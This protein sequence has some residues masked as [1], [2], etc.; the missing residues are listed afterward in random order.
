M[1][2]ST[3]G[4][5][6][7]ARAAGTGDAPRAATASVEPWG[8]AAPPPSPEDLPGPGRVAVWLLSLSANLAPAAVADG[9]LDAEEARR[10]ARFKDAGLRERYVTSHV[11]LRT[12]LG[13]YLGVDPAAVALTRELCGMPDCEKPHGRPALAEHT[14]LHFSLSHSEDAAMVAVA[15]SVVGADIESARA[16]RS[17]VDLTRALH[18]DERAAI[19]ALPESLRDEAFLS[20]WVRKEAY[21]KGIGTGLPGG[22]RTHH[23]GLAEGLAPAGSPVPAGW[24]LVDVAAPPGYHAAVAVRTPAGDTVAASGRPLVTLRHLTLG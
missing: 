22:I 19:A 15:R 11:G 9:M 14:G 23:V 8:P 1:L 24:A 10:A 12:L 21:L 20:C 4:T 13:G 3:A 6:Y 18:P 17:G 5:A 7:P 2:N 16:R